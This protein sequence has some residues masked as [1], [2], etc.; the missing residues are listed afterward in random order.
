MTSM[1]F[2]V[3]PVMKKLETNFGQQINL[4]QRAPLGALPQEVVTLLPH[5]IVTLT[6]LFISSYSSYWYQ[7][8]VVKTTHDRSR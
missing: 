7:T 3:P 4:I 8:R 6:N 2:Y 1:D 5:Y